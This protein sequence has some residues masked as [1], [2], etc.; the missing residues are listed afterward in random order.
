MLLL[1]LGKIC[2]AQ[3]GTVLCLTRSL[4]CLASDFILMQ[5]PVH[6][7]LFQILLYACSVT[8]RNANLCW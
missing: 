8:K 3:K 2:G 4:K 1:K 5:S 7:V 6:F